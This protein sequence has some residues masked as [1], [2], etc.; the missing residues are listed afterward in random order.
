M[1]PSDGQGPDSAPRTQQEL[2]PYSFSFE[3]V[4]NNPL[5]VGNIENPP[6]GMNLNELVQSPW[7]PTSIFLGNV[8]NK[9][10]LISKMASTVSYEIASS[11]VEV[12]SP[13]VNGSP[14]PPQAASGETNMLDD[15]L[16]HSSVADG[17]SV[18][19]DL[20]HPRP[21]ISSDPMSM[22]SEQQGSWVQLR[23][24]FDVSQ[25][26]N[27]VAVPG[28][29]NMSQDSIS[30]V[31]DMKK[32]RLQEENNDKTIE[33]RQRRMIKNRESAARS[34]AKKQV[35]N[36]TQSNGDFTQCLII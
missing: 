22:F 11:P 25:I 20:V 4:Q 15:L 34:R 32:S 16:A 1:S 14:L 8:V 6:N 24:G 30:A 18:Q 3:D 27:M 7:P 35:E 12:I 26:G 2:C 28:I 10:A 17:S 36:E 21:M 9:R 13:P 5:G 29:C 33:R 31:G 19:G 23:S